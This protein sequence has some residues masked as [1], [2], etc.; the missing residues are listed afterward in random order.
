LLNSSLIKV[1]FITFKETFLLSIFT[2]KNI[3]IHLM[4]I[5]THFLKK[6]SSSYIKKFDALDR[7]VFSVKD[8]H[9]SYGCI[10]DIYTKQKTKKKWAEKLLKWSYLVDFAFFFFF[11]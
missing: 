1:I 3:V 6:I 5:C 11:F 9:M 4:T 10:L 2:K 7:I 8:T